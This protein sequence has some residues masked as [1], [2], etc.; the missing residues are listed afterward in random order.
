MT[1]HKHSGPEGYMHNPGVVSKDAREQDPK[2]E[3]APDPKTP[4]RPV[5]PAPAIPV[6]SARVHPGYFGGQAPM[7]PAAMDAKFPEP[8]QEPKTDDNG[9]PQE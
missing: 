2:D 6:E 8:K 3:H 7:S 5:I 4:R 9:S 1:E